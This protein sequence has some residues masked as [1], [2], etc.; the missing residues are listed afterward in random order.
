MAG[1]VATTLFVV[2]ALAVPLPAAAQGA[3]P[4]TLYMRLRW[5][6]APGV[7]PT[8]DS[9]GEISGLALDRAG[10]VYASDFQAVTVWVF[11]SAGRSR[12][13]I[14]RKGEGPGEFT[15]PTGLG[16][17]PDGTL[18][19]RDVDR[20]NRFGLD[21]ATGALSRYEDSY[22]G[23][24]MTAWRSMQASRFDTS[25]ALLYPGHRWNQDGTARQYFMRY[26][27]SGALLDTIPVPTYA[28]DQQLTAWV[29]TSP[30]GGRMLFGLNHVP[31]AP[32]PVFDVTARGTVISG[33]ALTY[34]LRETDRDGRVVRVFRGS[35]ALPP[36]PRQERRDSLRALEARIDSIPVGLD[37]VKGMPES[38]RNK[39]LPETYPAY[40]AVYAAPD[41]TVW[42]RR[43][44]P[45]SEARTVFDVFSPAGAAILTVVLPRFIA[46]EP[47]PVLSVTGVVAL[48]VNP[49]TG[50]SAIL[51]FGPVRR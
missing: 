20:V 29:Q 17:S 10:N 4:D 9:L 19:V 36:I 28:N 43:W 49:A 14:G 45:R 21:A 7:H 35:G 23:P 18:Y 26:S 33:D 34:E 44:V 15:A 5:E 11:D 8:A 46:P 27:P 31:F 24:A 13:A 3:R 22:T 50:E 12:P 40:T 32:L 39:E 48:A 2:V 47:T 1:S 38:V 30:T 6:V 37:R 41:G 42:V 16:I 51:K 25:G